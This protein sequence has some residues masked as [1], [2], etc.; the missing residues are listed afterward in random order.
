MNNQEEKIKQEYLNG[1]KYSEIE[2]NNNISHSQ[3]ISFIQK[4]N[5]KRDKKYRSQ[6]QKGNKNAVGNKGGHAPKKNKNAVTTGE[7]EKIFDTV[8]DDDEKEILKSFSQGT[9][10]TILNELKLL[11]IREKRMLNRIQELKNK[12]RDMTIVKMSKSGDGTSTEIQNTL[13][14]INRIEDGLTRVQESKRRH[15]DLLY[16]IECDKGS[17]VE[18]PNEVAFKKN[19][20]LLE[21]IGRQLRNRGVQDGK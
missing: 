11:T 7:F 6:S 13:F 17:I 12:Q 8:L 15:L 3:L 21:S 16:K 1:L 18:K 19:T 4:N 14:L 20:N 5:L 9:K 10:E 2:R